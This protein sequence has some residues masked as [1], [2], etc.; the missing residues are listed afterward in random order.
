[1]KI[2]VTGAEGNVGSALTQYLVTKGHLVVPFVGS[3]TDY[4]NWDSY[5]GDFD[6]LIHLAGIA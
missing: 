2:L 6:A 4:W 1:M 3:V 5:V